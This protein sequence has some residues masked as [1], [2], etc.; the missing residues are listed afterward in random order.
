MKKN[1]TNRLSAIMA[2]AALFSILCFQSVSANAQCCGYELF[3][4]DSYGDGWNGA[5]LQVL[6]N[7]IPV[8][9]FSG[10]NYNSMAEIAICD[11]DSLDLVY[12]PG[13]YEHENAYE[14]LDFSWNLLF[15]DGP[16][17][18][19]GNV[20]AATG[21]CNT[22][23]LQGSH[24]C[25]A[26]PM[27]IGDCIFTNNTG[28]SGSGLNPHCAEYQGGDIWFTMLVPPSG[29]LSVET[30]SGNINDTGIAV[31][32][33][34]SC[35]NPYLVGCDDDGGNGYYSYLLIYDLTPGSTI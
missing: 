9:V 2:K 10:S 6:I 5:T 30:D 20:F 29:S 32:T 12:T 16:E 25:T 23:M 22:P 33:G 13:M 26:I 18:D 1:Y 28:F 3:M 8:G 35:T 15:Q 31:W 24:P 7:N 19:T 14:L 11:G 21:N 27:E 4:H 17:P 34:S